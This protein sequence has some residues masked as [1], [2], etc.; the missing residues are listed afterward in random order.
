MHWHHNLQLIYVSV[1]AIQV[2]MLD[3]TSQTPS[4][5]WDMYEALVSLCHIWLKMNQNITFPHPKLDATPKQR[6][7]K[8]IH[9]IEDHYFQDITLAQ[10]AHSA[11]ISISE[12]NRCFKAT[13]N[14]SPYK[15]LM[16]FRLTK[17]YRKQRLM[18]K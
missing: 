7:K 2:K 15:Y 10:L 1:G 11:D 18:Q 4:T 12:C 3:T 14:C 17:A 8:I 6:V 16:D 13:L 9:Y 5:P